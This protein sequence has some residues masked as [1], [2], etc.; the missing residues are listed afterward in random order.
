MKRYLED[1]GP[2]TRAAGG[3]QTPL[4]ELMV[5]NYSPLKAGTCMRAS[6]KTNPL[7]AMLGVPATA[8][9]TSGS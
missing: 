3:V 7:E 1:A 9:A 2:E 4:S 8:I 5:R 6:A